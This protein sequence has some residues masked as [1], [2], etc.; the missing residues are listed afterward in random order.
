MMM[1]SR[2]LKQSVHPIERVSS[3]QQ[4]Q[5]GLSFG[6]FKRDVK[7]TRDMFKECVV[8]GGLNQLGLVLWRWR[9]DLFV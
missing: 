8:G 2:V 4:F 3:I 6:L 5:D 9:N 1:L 7:H